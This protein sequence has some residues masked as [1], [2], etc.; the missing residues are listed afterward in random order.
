M[1]SALEGATHLIVTLPH[2]TNRDPLIASA[3]LINPAI[4]VFVRARYTGEQEELTAVG[5]DAVAYE[6]TEV[7]VALSRMVLA[8][9]GADDETIRRESRRIRRELTRT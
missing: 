2:S 9:Q 4:K 7:A 5:A 1:A 6:E 3:K 8:D